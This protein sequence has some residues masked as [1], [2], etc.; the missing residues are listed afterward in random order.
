MVSGRSGRG[1]AISCRPADF[2]AQ[3]QRSRPSTI[4]FP[5]IHAQ[6]QLFDSV[7]ANGVWKRADLVEKPPL[8]EAGSF[9]HPRL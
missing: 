3:W 4:S 6:V 8:D 2:K 5:Y 7:C 9:G 1:E